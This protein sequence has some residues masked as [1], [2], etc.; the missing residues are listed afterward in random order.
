MNARTSEQRSSSHLA[1][2]SSEN[3]SA[4]QQCASAPRPVVAASIVKPH[5]DDGGK[6]V[7]SCDGAAGDSRIATSVAAAQGKEKEEEEDKDPHGS[8]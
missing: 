8:F 5:V 2:R 7:R 1:V 4:V 3:S 6:F